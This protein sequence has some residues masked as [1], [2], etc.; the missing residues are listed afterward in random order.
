MSEEIMCD[1][2][3]LDEKA[4]K[5]VPCGEVLSLC[6]DLFKKLEETDLLIS[7]LTD[8]I[9]PILNE[10]P[11]EDKTDGCP[12]ENANTELGNNLISRVRTLILINKRLEDVID[13]VNL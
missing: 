8:R 4:P 10:N 13:R 1:S 6:D 7:Q 11:T 9:K 5:D 3:S 2:S 12:K